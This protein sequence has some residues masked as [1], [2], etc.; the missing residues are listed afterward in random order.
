[1]ITRVYEHYHKASNLSG[2]ATGST[3]KS[4]T[5]SVGGMELIS[6]TPPF[7]SFS[8]ILLSFLFYFTIHSILI[9]PFICVLIA[10][11]FFFP[12]TSSCAHSPLGFVHYVFFLALPVTGRLHP[13]TIIRKPNCSTEEIRLG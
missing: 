11:L 13:F 8:F 12:F 10:F 9:A 2:M 4:A 5:K 7:L 6:S 3:N 1:M